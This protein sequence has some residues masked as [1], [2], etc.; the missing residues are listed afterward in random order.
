MSKPT[1][2][3]AERHRDNSDMQ[4][5]PRRAR[6]EYEVSEIVKAFL[7]SKLLNVLYVLKIMRQIANNKIRPNKW[8]QTAHNG[9]V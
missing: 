3:S 7:S 2:C 1:G 4:R 8:L 9:A 6:V 5:P